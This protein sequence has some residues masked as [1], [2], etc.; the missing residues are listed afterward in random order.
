MHVCVYVCKIYQNRK[1]R[2]SF[3]CK[4]QQR[5]KYNRKKRA[6][7]FSHIQEHFQF[8]NVFIRIQNKILDCHIGPTQNTILRNT[9]K[10]LVLALHSAFYNSFVSL[11]L[12]S[13]K[14]VPLVMSTQV[15]TASNLALKKHNSFNEQE[16]NQ[17]F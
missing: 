10:R 1:I 8:K 9:S 7:K 4:I 13:L 17:E 2:N 6:L 14:Q 11:Y 15:C 3:C 12:Q 5:G 16:I